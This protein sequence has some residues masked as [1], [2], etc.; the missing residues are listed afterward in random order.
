[1]TMTI[2]TLN[3]Y[4]SSPYVRVCNSGIASY[5]AV[6]VTGRQGKP[7]AQTKG[8][9]EDKRQQH[10]LSWHSLPKTNQTQTVKSKIMST[11]SSQS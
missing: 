10:L 7:A 5:V 1:M 11:V 9:Q 4:D 3:Y 2:M 8:C 6:K